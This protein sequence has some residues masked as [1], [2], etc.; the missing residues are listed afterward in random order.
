MPQRRRT[1]GAMIHHEILMET[2]PDYRQQR[3]SI[4][5][6]SR[7]Y[8]TDPARARAVFPIITIPVVIHVVYNNNAQN[9]SD[10]QIE[11]QIRILNEDYRMQ[12]ADRS[13]IPEPFKPVAADAKIEFK[14]AVRAPDGQTTNGITR[15]FTRETSFDY[16]F[17]TVKFNSTGGKDAWPRDK[18]LNMW[19]CNLSGGLLGYAQFPGGSAATDGVVMDY[20]YFGDIG[21]ATSP[22]DK[23][24]TTTHEVGHWLNLR[25]IWGDDNGACTGSDQVDDTPNQADA[26]FGRPT[27]PHITCNN[28]PHGD[29]FMNYM[30]YTDDAG[31][32]M[33]SA[34]QVARMWATLD[35]PR[36]SI[37]TSDALIPPA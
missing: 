14:L 35:G 2:D 10:A 19:I 25:H 28:G 22:F 4:E 29:M 32:F 12:N 7:E 1:C 11:S 6:A 13:E 24:R 34:D 30:D 37:K 27:F 20:Q 5:M 8:E 16:R 21:T 26:N 15:T 33:F 18:Y 17:E 9:I 23:G 36:A 31:M 3:L